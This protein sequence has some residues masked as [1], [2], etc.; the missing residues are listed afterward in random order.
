MKMD[1]LGDEMN[2]IGKKRLDLNIDEV[3]RVKKYAGKLYE[4]AKETS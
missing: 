3:V 1:K 4:E 2:L